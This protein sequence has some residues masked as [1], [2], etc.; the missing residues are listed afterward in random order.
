M[1]CERTSHFAVAGSLP[2]HRTGSVLDSV[3][4]PSSSCDDAVKAGRYSRTSTGNIWPCVRGPGGTGAGGEAERRTRAGAGGKAQA[5]GRR[6]GWLAHLLRGE[7][8]AAVHAV[9]PGVLHPH[10]P[11]IGAPPDARGQEARV[12]ILFIVHT[13]GPHGKR[14]KAGLATLLHVLSQTTKKASHPKPE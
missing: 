11:T 6:G 13:V 2:P 9:L 1:A 5:A 4:V 8:L 12:T 7:R 14:N 10:K 3:T